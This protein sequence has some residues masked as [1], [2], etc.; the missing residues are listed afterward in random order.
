MNDEAQQV[1]VAVSRLLQ[2]QVIDSG[3][4]LA[5]RLEAA[6][7]RE[8]AVLV[9]RLVADDLRTHLVDTLDSAAHLSNS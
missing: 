2:V 5:M 4:T 7:G 1:V 9:P 8:L 3:R 6:D